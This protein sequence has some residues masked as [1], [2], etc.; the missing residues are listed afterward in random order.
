MAWNR[1]NGCSYKYKVKIDLCGIL[2]AIID[3]L[4]GDLDDWDFDGENVVIYMSDRA[5]ADI[6]HCRQTLYE[7]EEYEID[8]KSYIEDDVDVNKEVL[9]ALHGI[10]QIATETD[11]DYES[12]EVD[13]NYGPDPDRAYDEWRD[14]Q[15]EGED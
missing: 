3:N 13:E 5:L 8:L 9:D 11:V 4:P 2:D 10:K 15:M 12:I 14:R 7:P 1:N 6:W